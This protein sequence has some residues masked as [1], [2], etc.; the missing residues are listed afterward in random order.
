MRKEDLKDLSIGDTVY[1]KGRCLYKGHQGVVKNKNER[2]VE[3]EIIAN[4]DIKWFYYGLLDLVRKGNKQE[5]TQPSSET[6]S[7]TNEKTT[8]CTFISL[9]EVLMLL[10]NKDVNSIY[11][12]YL[13]Q[14]TLGQIVSFKPLLK[15]DI[16]DLLNPGSIFLKIS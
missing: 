8:R 5:D 13:D 14:E 4:G 15:M 6:K 11:V 1:I 16:E 7:E 12:G 10:K 2:K 3:V 9:D